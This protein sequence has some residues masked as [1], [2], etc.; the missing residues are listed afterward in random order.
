MIDEKGIFHLRDG[1][2]NYQIEPNN[3]IYEKAIE[4]YNDLKQEYENF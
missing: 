4:I 1:V 3:N 2:E